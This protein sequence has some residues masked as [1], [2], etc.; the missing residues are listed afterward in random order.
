MSSIQTLQQG[1]MGTCR[2]ARVR[3]VTTEHGGEAN[4]SGG[5][6]CNGEGVEST[7]RVHSIQDEVCGEIIEYQEEPTSHRGDRVAEGVSRT[8]P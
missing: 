3:E 5:S 7:Y 4:T 6:P 1:C 2:G 8:F